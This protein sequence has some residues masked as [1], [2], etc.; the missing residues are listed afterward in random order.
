[1]WQAFAP[2]IQALVD[3]MENKTMKPAPF[4]PLA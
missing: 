2:K 4:S 1:M 3:E